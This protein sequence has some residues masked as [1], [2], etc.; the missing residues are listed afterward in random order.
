MSNVSS[1]VNAHNI[2]DF[3]PRQWYIILVVGK[4]VFKRLF[5][6]SYFEEN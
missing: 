1:M 2:F 4:S 6:L 3:F 5:S